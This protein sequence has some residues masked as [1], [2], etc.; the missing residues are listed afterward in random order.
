M[1]TRRTFIK[2][3]SAATLAMSLPL[4]ILASP[5]SKLIGIQLYTIRDEVRKDFSGTLKKIAEAGYNSVE[6]AGYSGRKFYGYTPEDYKKICED[7]GLLP[8][9]SHTSFDMESAGQVIEDTLAGGM[10]WVVIPSI[11]REKRENPDSYRKLAD[12]LNRL[13]EKCKENGLGFAYHNHAFE[14]ENM[15]GE[16]PYDILLRNTEPENVTM[17]LDMYWMVYG[18][19]QPMDY[20]NEFP[21]RFKLWHVKDM[22]ADPGRES[23]EIGSGII[24]WPELFAAKEKAGMEMFYVEQESFK[25]DPF[26]SIKKSCDYLKTLEY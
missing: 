20:F 7:L 24:D 2:T 26:E 12:E 15:E 22:D 25:T 11:P 6:A 21:G 8:T 23:T 1:Q 9:S 3:A 17:E 19:R 4:S 13:G 10:S 14:F 16:T 5:G 18:G